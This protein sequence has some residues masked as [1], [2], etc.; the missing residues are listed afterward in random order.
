M[1]DVTFSAKDRHRVTVRLD[2]TKLK[3]R[4]EFEEMREG[5]SWA[6]DSSKSFLETGRAIPSP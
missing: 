6:L 3:S 1:V 5:W 4:A 2:H